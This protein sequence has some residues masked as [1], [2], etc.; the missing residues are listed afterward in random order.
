VLIHSLLLLLLLQARENLKASTA[1]VWMKSAIVER[2]AGDNAAQRKLLEEGLKRF[3]ADWKLWMMLGQVSCG[4][5]LGLQW[6]R[7]WAMGL[8]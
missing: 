3:P 7:S 8:G 2:E 6:A 1:R 5:R 4:W